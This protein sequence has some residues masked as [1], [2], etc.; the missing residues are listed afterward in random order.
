MRRARILIA[1][2][3]LVGTLLMFTP[4]ALAHVGNGGQGWF[5]ETTDKSITNVMFA[6]IAFFP[7]V[8]IV[9]SLIQSWLDRRHHAREDAERARATSA[10]WRGGW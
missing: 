5:G 7:L 3:T 8:I 4:A 9:F 2:T 6:T 1:L 10:E